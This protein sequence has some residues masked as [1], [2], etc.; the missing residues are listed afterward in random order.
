MEMAEHVFKSSISRSKHDKRNIVFSKR[1][2][3]FSHQV[4]AFL[5]GEARD[6]TNHWT[7]RLVGKTHL[8]QQLALALSLAAQITG[9]K[10]G[11]DQRV[12]FRTPFPVIDPIQYPIQFV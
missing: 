9:G 11:G 3:D 7:F 12:N 4:E 6:N 1:R 10:V 5:I 8:G 2:G